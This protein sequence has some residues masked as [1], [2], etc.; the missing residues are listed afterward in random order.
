M[1]K[2]E[3]CGRKW[4][5]CYEVLKVDGDYEEHMKIISGTR[6]EV[7]TPQKRSKKP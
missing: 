1:M 6:L 4:S 7:K 3:G 2:W 5:L